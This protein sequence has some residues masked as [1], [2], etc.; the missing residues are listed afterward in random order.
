MQN[1]SPS[2]ELTRELRDFVL[3]YVD[4]PPWSQD[5]RTLQAIDDAW[6]AGYR[7]PWDLAIQ[8]RRRLWGWR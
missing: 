4:L 7:T 8:V 1:D 3:T 5:A 2:T 6:G